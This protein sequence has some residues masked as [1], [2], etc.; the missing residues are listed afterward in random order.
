MLVLEAAP[1]GVSGLRHT[2]FIFLGDPRNCGL[3]VLMH[4]GLLRSRVCFVVCILLVP[5]LHTWL[6]K[7]RHPGGDRDMGKKKHIRSG[8]HSPFLQGAY[9]LARK[10]T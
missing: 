1:D 8:Q 5:R 4:S 2:G 3:S 6:L 9:N 10:Q 7:G